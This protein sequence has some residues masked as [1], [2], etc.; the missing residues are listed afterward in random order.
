MACHVR[1]V[2]S[3]RKLLP[4][5]RQWRT[6]RVSLTVNQRENVRRNAVQFLKVRLYLAI[7]HLASPHWQKDNFVILSKMTEKLLHGQ[8]ISCPFDEKDLIEAEFSIASKTQFTKEF[9]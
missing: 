6:C 8:N 9:R 2:A 1:C 4:L 3:F 7:Y 5:R